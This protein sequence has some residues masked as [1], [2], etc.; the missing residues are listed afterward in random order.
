MSV[1]AANAVQFI[2]IINGLVII[3]ILLDIGICSNNCSFFTSVKAYAVKSHYICHV[4]ESDMYGKYL[5][6]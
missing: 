4:R 2:I 1:L 3:C 6:I 5:C